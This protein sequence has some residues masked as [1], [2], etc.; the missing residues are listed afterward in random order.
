MPLTS[1]RPPKLRFPRERIL[2]RESGTDT[3]RWG[4][5]RAIANEPDGGDEF[6]VEAIF[7]P[8]TT[9]SSHPICGQNGA[10]N[11]GWYL[12][13]SGSSDL[14]F[15]INDTNSYSWGLGGLTAGR[16]Y[17]AAFVYSPTAQ[18]DYVK[19]YGARLGLALAGTEANE[20]FKVGTSHSLTADMTAA[21]LGTYM[22]RSGWAT[23]FDGKMTMLRVWRRALSEGEIRRVWNQRWTEFKDTPLPSLAFYYD[24]GFGPAAG[25]AAI[26]GSYREM[27]TGESATGIGDVKVNL[28]Q[29][30]QPWIENV[31]EKQ[32]WWAVLAAS[33]ANL[34]RTITSSISHTSAAPRAV[35]N[36]RVPS[37]SVSHAA[38][39]ARAVGNTRTATSSISHTA[40]V[41]RAVANVRTLTSSIA[42]VAPI[43][44]VLA[45]SRTLTSSIA[46][47]AAVTRLAA[48]SRTITSSIANS[49][50]LARA[51]AF[52]R[53]LSSSIASSVVT[54]GSVNGGAVNVT[55]TV[56]SSISHAAAVLRSVALNRSISSSIAAS[57]G[58]Q[59]AL[60]IARGVT[61]TIAHTAVL[62][63][64][65]TLTR[66]LTSSIGATTVVTKA[67]AATRTLTSTIAQSTAVARVGGFIRSVLSAIAH[68]VGISFPGQ[69]PTG[70]IVDGVGAGRFITTV[71][72][73]GAGR[74]V[75]GVEGLGTGRYVSTVEG[76]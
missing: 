43:A 53:A 59:R 2:D 6:T 41:A 14:Q 35:A 33:A 60:A 19:A 30:R 1:P 57:T 4:S 76:E 48:A 69:V 74:Y 3:L 11:N 54:S 45:L 31:G 63:R 21:D 38:T 28:L 8:D 17:Y 47:T 26:T 16:W 24:A 46:H 75:T 50:V 42:H 7:R 52:V 12:Y 29:G 40:L 5:S 70:R 66:S 34:T 15:W 67:V 55:R 62:A 65:L 18:G 25:M 22:L 32:R 13:R 27:V 37:S 51:G 44:R 39:L 56:T 36:T 20:A 72:G 58:T 9:I 71:E 23:E 49:V 73:E 10:S 64:V 61:S 68:A